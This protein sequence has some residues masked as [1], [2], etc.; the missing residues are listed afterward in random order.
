MRALTRGFFDARQTF[1][2]ILARI[3]AAAHLNQRYIG[4]IMVALFRFHFAIITLLARLDSL[5]YTLSVNSS[6]SNPVPEQ[7]VTR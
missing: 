6:S 7:W 2:Q 3:V 1:I 5:R 4:F